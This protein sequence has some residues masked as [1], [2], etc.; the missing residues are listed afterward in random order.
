MRLAALGHSGSSVRKVGPLV[1]KTGPLRMLEGVAKQ[2]A[3]PSVRLPSVPVVAAWAMG[4]RGVVVMRHQAGLAAVERVD[5]ART[6]AHAALA[7][8]RGNVLPGSVSAWRLA[9]RL[10]NTVKTWRA[11]SVAKALATLSLPAGRCHGDLTLSN[12]IVEGSR[13]HVLDFASLPIESPAIDACKLLQD[14]VHGW[15]VRIAPRIADERAL[16]A[17]CEVLLPALQRL[18]GYSTWGDVLMAWTLLRAW[19]YAA[20]ELREWIEREVDACMF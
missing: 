3:N 19:P 12:I 9:E 1:V 2:R 18:P 11:K 7:Y 17:A 13:A 5:V 20:P 15:A 10:V 6:A 8:V 4:D 14:A 16:N